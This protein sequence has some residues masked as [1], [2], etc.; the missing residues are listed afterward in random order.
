MDST[1]DPSADGLWNSVA[2]ISTVNG[3]EKREP[4]TDEDWKAVRRHAITLI[5]AMNL[6]M[7]EGRH[8]APPGTAPGAGELSPAQID[9]MIAGNRPEFDQFAQ[10]VQDSGVKAL[11]AIDRKDPKALFDVGSEID[12]RCESCHVTFWYPGSARPSR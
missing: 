6:A 9:S 3:V 4:R 2:T 8:A 12:S 7:M 1:V 11:S 10:A 5:E